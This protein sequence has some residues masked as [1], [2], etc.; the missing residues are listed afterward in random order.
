[1]DFLV[2][3]GADPK[4]NRSTAFKNSCGQYRAGV[5]KKFIDDFGMDPHMD[6]EMPMRRVVE[7]NIEHQAGN[8]KYLALIWEAMQ[9]LLDYF[10]KGA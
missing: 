5:M 6:G 4:F 10:K 3:H 2:Q 8:P 9:L 1:M 7:G